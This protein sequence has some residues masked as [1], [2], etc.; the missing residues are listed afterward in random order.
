MIKAISAFTNPGIMRWA[1]KT[2]RMSIDDVARKI[3]K[4]PEVIEAWENGDD[5]PTINQLRALSNLYKRP[6]SV[7][8]L[9]KPPEDFQTIRDFRKLPKGYSKEFSSDLAFLIR[10]TQSKQVWVRDHLISENYEKLT[11]IG[12]GQISDSTKTLSSEIRKE[13]GLSIADQMESKDCDRAFRLL[14]DRVEE[15]GIFVFR[16]LG[17]DSREVRGFVL[18]DDYAP[19]IFINAED[20]AAGQL[21]TLAHELVHLWINQSGISN[22]EPFKEAKT[23]EEGIERFCNQVASEF[24]VPDEVFNKFVKNLGTVN[25]NEEAINDI[26]KIFKVSREVIARKFLN[27]GIINFQDYEGLREKYI[28]EWQKFKELRKKKLKEKE[29]TAFVY[30]P[31]TL[32][33]NGIAFTRMALSAYYSRQ[34]S[35]RDVS[36]LLGVKINNLGKLAAYAKYKK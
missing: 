4:S 12:K 31:L 25:S 30:Y 24:L 14:M 17:I 9:P 5:K 29:S 15:K 7:F 2:S 8:Y 33:A 23:K 32:N 18:C 21:F 34:L 1:R 27:K 20:S 28:K 11:F 6:L 35:G 10:D 13:L 26:S 36:G 3:Q 16:Q 19:F 22:N